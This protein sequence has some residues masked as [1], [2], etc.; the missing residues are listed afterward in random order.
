MTTL[1][2]PQLA[3]A[4]RLCG[5]PASP[6]FRQTILDRHDAAYFQCAVCDLIQT[7]PPYWLDEAYA[8]ALCAA[9][10]GAIHRNLLTADLTTA[11]ARLLGLT[12][13]SRCLDYGGG[14]GVFVRMMRDRGFDFRLHDRY[15]ENLFAPGFEADP[16]APFDLVTAFEVVEHFADVATDLKRLFGSRPRCLLISTQLHRGHEPGWWYYTPHTGQHI[17]FYSEKTMRRIA[18][19]FGYRVAGS[20][21]YTLFIRDDSEIAAWRI[22]L[23]QRLIRSSRGD[24]SNVWILALAHLAPPFPSR[25]IS[26]SDRLMPP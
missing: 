5:A 8:S 6:I 26:D 11:L 16:G 25:T 1:A 7:E 4:C 20:R 13:R 9:D 17:A 3:A 18:G 12:P 15:A 14:H 19:D 10:T 22:T 2:A 23:A 21:A 24:R